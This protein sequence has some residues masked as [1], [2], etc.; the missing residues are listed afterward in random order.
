MC[1][2]IDRDNLFMVDVFAKCGT[3]NN[4]FTVNSEQFDIAL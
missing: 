2:V 4:D 1:V 3:T